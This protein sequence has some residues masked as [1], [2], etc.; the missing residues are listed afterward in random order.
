MKKKLLLFSIILL[1][2]VSVSKAIP[3]TLS[4][5]ISGNLTIK[6]GTTEQY[7]AALLALEQEL[8]AEEDNSVED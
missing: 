4:C 6:N 1:L 5:G 2:S 3:Y 7:I 8:C